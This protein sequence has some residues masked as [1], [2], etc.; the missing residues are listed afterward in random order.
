MRLSL[1]RAPTWPDPVADRGRHRFTYRLLPHSGDLRDAGVIDAG[2]DLNVPLR[3][4]PVAPRSG[5]RPRSHSLIELDAPNVVLEVVKQPDGDAPDGAL[6][7]R[8]YESWGRRGPVTVRVP[9]RLAR[10]ARTDLLERDQ[11]PV[12]VDGTRVALDVT[13]FEIVTL[14]LH[15]EHAA[16]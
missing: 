9:R 10:A 15:P 7:L 6:V 12:P 11:Q 8:L 2:Y 5:P 14:V 1:L 4:V 3:A 13:P 16:T